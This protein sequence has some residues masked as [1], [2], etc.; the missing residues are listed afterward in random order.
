MRLLLWHVDHFGAEPTS[1]GRSKVADDIP[2]AVQVDEAVVVFAQSEKADE[3]DPPGVARRTSDAIA[4]VA[5]GLKAHCIVLHSFAHLFGELSAPAVACTVLGLTE[6]A[7]VERGYE[8][9]QTAFG[10]F[11]QLDL[12]AKGHPYSRQARQL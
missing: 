9:Q 3:A 5:A 8:V 4:E 1:R 10:W 2:A 11:N 12:R 6:Q 7:L